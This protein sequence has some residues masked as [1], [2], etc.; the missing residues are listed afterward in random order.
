LGKSELT[1]SCSLIKGRNGSRVLRRPQQIPSLHTALPHTDAL[2]N[3]LDTRPSL[4]SAQTPPTLRSVSI[5]AAAESAPVDDKCHCHELVCSSLKRHIHLIP[6]CVVTQKAARC[7]FAGKALTCGP[8]RAVQNLANRSSVNAR[9]SLSPATTAPLLR[10]H[11]ERADKSPAHQSASAARPGRGPFP[12][13]ASAAAAATP[14]QL[15]RAGILARRYSPRPSRSTHCRLST[16][17]RPLDERFSAEATAGWDEFRTNANVHRF[18]SAN[19]SDHA[20]SNRNTIRPKR[21][22]R[23]HHRPFYARIVKRRSLSQFQR[24]RKRA[25]PR[26]PAK[27]DI[28]PTFCPR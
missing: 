2:N 21:A 8:V 6:T 11:V 14:E 5:A 3:T 22:P 28:P 7:W 15:L 12:E 23:F 19:K 18:S 20:P 1:R 17:C 25:I 24:Q 4:S 10:R 9:N 16:N 26:I 13:P 27:C